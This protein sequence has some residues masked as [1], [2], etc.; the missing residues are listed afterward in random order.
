MLDEGI[1]KMRRIWTL[2]VNVKNKAGGLCGNNLQSCPPGPG[3]A[4]LT[5]S[6]FLMSTLVLSFVINSLYVTKMRKQRVP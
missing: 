5:L 3:R 6:W 2:V 1:W 4:Q